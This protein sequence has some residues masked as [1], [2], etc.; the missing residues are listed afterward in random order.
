MVHQATGRH[1]CFRGLQKSQ[2]VRLENP[3]SP[4]DVWNF[5]TI[6]PPIFQ[7]GR[8]KKKKKKK[9]VIMQNMSHY[10][11]FCPYLIL[12]PATADQDGCIDFSLPCY[13]SP[14]G[15]WQLAGLMSTAHMVA[16]LICGWDSGSVQ[17][18]R[19]IYCRGC[20]KPKP[21]E[22]YP[23]VPCGKAWHS[24]VVAEPNDCARNAKIRGAHF[25][26]TSR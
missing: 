13:S 19:L 21:R 18:N 9:N 26:V 23:Q 24:P 22:R 16:C 4:P 1:W 14:T 5:L 2:W 7:P 12:K 17:T 8:V 11:H 25:C 15:I 6:S 20:R 10:P 3:L